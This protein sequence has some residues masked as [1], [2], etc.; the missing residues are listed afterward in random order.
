[1]SE[2]SGVVRS[3]N[4]ER[5]ITMKK[6]LLYFSLLQKCAKKIHGTVHSSLRVAQK[7]YYIFVAHSTTYYELRTVFV[8]FVCNFIGI[9]DPTLP[10]RPSMQP[11]S[12][13]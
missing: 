11:P 2:L 13:T 8:L 7:V 12:T 1:M 5:S 10:P 6:K 4:D 3:P 9:S